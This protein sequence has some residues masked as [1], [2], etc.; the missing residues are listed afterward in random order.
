MSMKYGDKKGKKNCL[1][2]VY[3]SLNRPYK[4]NYLIYMVCLGLNLMNI[5]HLENYII[6]FTAAE[7][8]HLNSFP[9]SST[10]STSSLT[11]E[12]FT[13]PLSLSLTIN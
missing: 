2:N 3:L 13:F 11:Q 1:H 9:F 7:G 6:I 10:F 8:I 5:N 12:Y 4:M